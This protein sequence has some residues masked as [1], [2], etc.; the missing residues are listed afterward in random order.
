MLAFPLESEY[1]DFAQLYHPTLPKAGDKGFPRPWIGHHSP[2]AGREPVPKGQEVR[3]LPI[4]LRSDDGAMKEQGKMGRKCN[5]TLPDC[6][7]DEGCGFER[8]V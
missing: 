5:P 8:T 3:T 7:G 6:A 4:T 1:N 2:F